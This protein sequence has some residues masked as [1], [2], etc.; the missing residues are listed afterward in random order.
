MRDLL[1]MDIPSLVP[2]LLPLRVSLSVDSSWHGRAAC[3]A[4][5]MVD[6]AAADLIAEDRLIAG[7]LHGQS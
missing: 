4:G 3:V 7:L 1:P 5:C 6:N 2:Q